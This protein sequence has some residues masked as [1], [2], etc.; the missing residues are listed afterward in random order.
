MGR[1]EPTV[2][3]QKPFLFLFSLQT[4][5]AEKVIV[6]K[7]E[8]AWRFVRKFPCGVLNLNTNFALNHPRLLSSPGFSRVRPSTPAC[9]Q[10]GEAPPSGGEGLTLPCRQAGLR[11]STISLAGSDPFKVSLPADAS[12]Q[13]LQAGDQGQTLV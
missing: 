5:E 13:A 8:T 2:K 10:A 6:L 7:E 1:I 12:R 9:R 11:P 4:I 3:Y